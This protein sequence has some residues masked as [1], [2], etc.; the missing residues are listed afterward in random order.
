MELYTY[1]LRLKNTD[2]EKSISMTKKDGRLYL[3]TSDR[4]VNEEKI[5]MEEA[6]N[7]GLD[8]LKKIGIDNVKETY[9]LKTENYALINYAA[10]QD[11]VILY[12][13]LV[14][15]KI[16][17]DNGEVDSVE[18]QGYIFN[19]TKRDDITPTISIDEARSK[20]NKKLEIIAEDIAIIPTDSN[21]EILTYEFKGKIDD[22]EFLIYIN[23]KTSQEERILLILETEGGTLTM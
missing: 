22:R 16:A 23:A 2:Y 10:M 15:V 6:E 12:P 14:K 20:I 21:S 9:Y 4:D 3:M 11:D 7:I 8:F 13:D 17:L 1:T 19:H 5:S 18:S